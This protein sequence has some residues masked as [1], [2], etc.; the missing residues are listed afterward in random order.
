MSTFLYS[1]RASC[2]SLRMHL[3]LPHGFLPVCQVW[4]MLDRG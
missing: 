2:R 4:M 3:V 1:V